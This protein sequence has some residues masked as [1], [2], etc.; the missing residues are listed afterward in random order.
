MTRTELI[1]HLN[2]LDASRTQG[3]WVVQQDVDTFPVHVA[4]FDGNSIA[5]LFCNFSDGVDNPDAQFIAAAPQMMQ[6]INEQQAE[7]EGLERALQGYVT[8]H[9][10]DCLSL[11][12]MRVAQEALGITTNEGGGD[13]E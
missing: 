3:D 6:L 11:T 8:A 5:E 12:E 10:D 13:A 9:N 4:E 1:A 2:E 7:I